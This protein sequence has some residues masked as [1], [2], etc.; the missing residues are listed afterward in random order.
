MKPFES[1]HIE[2]AF[3]YCLG[4]EDSDYKTNNNSIYMWNT[5]I[6]LGLW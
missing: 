2:I 6:I 1:S 3:I 4:S 5:D